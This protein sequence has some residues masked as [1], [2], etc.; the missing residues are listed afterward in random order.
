MSAA[1]LGVTMREEL[2]SRTDA[3]ALA[4]LDTRA[5]L[6]L[7]LELRVDVLHDDAEKAALSAVCTTSPTKE[8]LADF[9][10]SLVA[11][12]RWVH[13]YARVPDRHDLVVVGVAPGDANVALLRTWIRTI[14]ERV[15]SRR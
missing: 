10:E 12:G 1:G 3:V 11:S 8:E 4:C 9:D 14:A 2:A 5:G 6:V 13:A 7:G 15:G